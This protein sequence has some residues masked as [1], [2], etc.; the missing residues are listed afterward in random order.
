MNENTHC[1]LSKQSN[2]KHLLCSSYL[3]PVQLQGMASKGA[4][5]C[6]CR[7]G[8]EAT[9]LRE[10]K[11]YKYQNCPFASNRKAP[12]DD[13]EPYEIDE[14]VV[15]LY[16]LLKNQFDCVVY[17]LSKSFDIR[18]SENFWRDALTLFLGSHGYCYPWLTEAN[19][20]YIFAYKGM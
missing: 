3:N 16:E 19:L 9:D 17:I 2:E 15:E 7:A 4:E 8:K 10:W 13:Y 20:P 6:D 5:S 18:C 12:S 14:D 1:P 11:Y